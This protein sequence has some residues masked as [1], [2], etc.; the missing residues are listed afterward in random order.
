[1][2][3]KR[4]FVHSTRRRVFV[5]VAIVLA[6]FA[7]ALAAVTV[8][9]ES[10]IV[11][12]VS[13]LPPAPSVGTEA[14]LISES[15][16]ADA[17]EVAPG[18]SESESEPALDY[19]EADLSSVA[20][21]RLLVK[22]SEETEPAQQQA[23]LS[24]VGVV[25][26]EDLGLGWV[27]VE[28]A[29]QTTASDVE[30]TLAASATVEVE[31][32]LPMWNVDATP[33]DPSY[34]SEWGLHQ[35]NDVDIDAPE[36]WDL[37]TGSSNVIVAVTD[38]GVDINHPDL[39][40][41]I[42]TNPGET[43]GNGIDDDGNGLVDDVNGWD[44][45]NDDSSV[46]DPSE[47]DEH[48][49]HVAGT[50]GARTNNG[51][52]IAGVNWGV[53]LLP[54]KFLG[55]FGGWTSDAIDCIN[56]VVGEGVQVINASWGGGS[57]SQSLKDAID[58]AGNNGVVFVA[59]A[60]NSNQNTDVY[61]HYPSSYTSSNL[62]SV[63]SISSSG[64]RSSFSN[65]GAVSVD[66]A[67]PGS[68]VLSTVPGGYQYFSGTSMATPHVAG[69]AALV[70][71]SGVSGD[72]A[73]GAILDGAV[74]ISAMSGITT[75]G[76]LLNAKKALT[77]S[78]VTSITN[79]TDG[80]RIHSDFN[81]DGKADLAVL[82][83]YANNHIRIWVLRA[84][85]TNDGFHAPEMWYDSGAGGWNWSSS[86]LLA[87]DFTGD[88]RDDIAAAYDYGG[89]HMRI[90]VFPANSS[91]TAFDDKVLYYDS[92]AGG[93][94]LFASYWFAA[95][96]NADGVADAVAFENYASNRVR[97][98]VFVNTGSTFNQPSTWYDSGPG[99]WDWDASQVVVSDFTGDGRDDFGILYDYGNR[100]VRLWVLPS[101]STG[102]GFDVI[103]EW[104]DSGPGNW[105]WHQSYVVGGDY[106]G[107]GKGDMAIVYDY[108][109]W[110]VRFWVL[111]ANSTGTSFDPMEMWFN[112]GPG[113]W[114]PNQGRM[115]IDDFTGDTRDDVA[116]L[117][118]YG[119]M[120]TR[121]WNLTSQS[122]NTFTSPQ[123]WY[124]SGL[125]NW[126]ALQ[127]LMQ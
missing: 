115:I 58:N 34:G 121:F 21:D 29:S 126:D 2:A 96:V 122:N 69:V 83:N 62:I 48:G 7:L 52:G 33:N 85:S 28:V 4:Q 20:T 68:S 98:R 74:P 50:I 42:W 91:Q 118:R 84:K 101:N 116:V 117:Y 66:L 27:A 54:C 70:T 112:S 38:T 47:G 111:P 119:G 53:T 90:W 104:Y 124:D 89:S 61:P 75:T 106:T 63:A 9:T 65:Y 43:P 49:T 94:N 67:A 31:P 1:M 60:G 25:S 56:Y 77:G 80:T 97:F 19:S 10:L 41:Q 22:F 23:A 81:G 73:R 103:A 108:L 72:D 12:D 30:A 109:N 114:D 78:P 113:N 88:G 8:P 3:S 71:S 59:A 64:A 32:D 13:P 86:R 120:Q 16:D 15:V 5:S 100:H 24:Q 57:Y 6:G 36:A 17:R 44:F 95:D 123:M 11:A 93:W 125:G 99:N 76:G 105:D 18:A 79:P 110:H 39:A 51:L 35:A 82:Y 102:T 45:Y 127:S 37:Q 107:D 87:G 40:G 14:P 46:Y 26:T 92:G 55:P